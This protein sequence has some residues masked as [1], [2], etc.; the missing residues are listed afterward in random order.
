MGLHQKVRHMR[1]DN[2]LPCALSFKLIDISFTLLVSLARA[3]R[4][5][6]VA[7]FFPVYGRWPLLEARRPINGGGWG[8]Q[9]DAS[10]GRAT[11]TSLL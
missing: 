11:A 2:E 6:P 8:M 10:V 3:E 7:A 4:D 9:P 1:D 5:G